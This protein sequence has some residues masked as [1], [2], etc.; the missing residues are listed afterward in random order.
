MRRRARVQT[1][2]RIR[3]DFKTNASRETCTREKRTPHLTAC[4]TRRLANNF[5]NK[6][7]TPR[8]GT[9]HS[10]HYKRFDVSTFNCVIR[11]GTCA[12][13]DRETDQTVQRNRHETGEVND[14]QAWKTDNRRGRTET[15]TEGTRE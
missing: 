3:S 9:G 1:A 7:H 6:R 8:N 2:D 11:R 13:R 5:E 12:V 15:E 10:L 4:T 14:R